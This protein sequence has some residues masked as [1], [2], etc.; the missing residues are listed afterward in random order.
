MKDVVQ[1]N[2]DFQKIIFDIADISLVE[3]NDRYTR[4]LRQYIC[5]GMC[6]QDYGNLT[7]AMRNAERIEVGRRA[8]PYNKAK[9]DENIK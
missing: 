2:I 6:I 3:Q 5:K 8:Y 1:F 4:G 9:Y 7:E